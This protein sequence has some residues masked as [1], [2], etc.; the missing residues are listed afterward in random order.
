MVDST[1]H[2]WL[3]EVNAFPDFAQSGNGV[4]KEVVQGL[5]EGVL[6]LVGMAWFNGGKVE[7][8]GNGIKGRWGMRKVLDVDLG[9]R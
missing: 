5:W 6:G 1:G 4:G 8:E 9:R 7:E 3:L 2:V